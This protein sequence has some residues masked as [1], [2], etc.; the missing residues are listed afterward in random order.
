[1]IREGPNIGDDSD[2]IISNKIHED[3][4]FF[5]N[6]DDEDDED[7]YIASLQFGPEQTAVYSREFAAAAAPCCP[8]GCMEGRVREATLNDLRGMERETEDEMRVAFL[9]LRK[10]RHAVSRK[11]CEY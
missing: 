6:N 2:N 4:Y 3:D 1:M 10:A 5:V 8:N 9:D 7:A 11:T